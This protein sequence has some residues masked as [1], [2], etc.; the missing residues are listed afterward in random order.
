MK[1]KTL[2]FYKVIWFALINNPVHSID[3]DIRINPIIKS[4]FLPNLSIKVKAIN[5]VINAT[6]AAKIATSFPA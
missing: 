2:I 4:V 1:N 6:I 5:D 3:S